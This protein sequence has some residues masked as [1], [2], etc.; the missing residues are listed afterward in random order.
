MPAGM[1]TAVNLSHFEKDYFSQ[2]LE[3]AQVQT[4]QIFDIFF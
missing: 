2:N 1:I 4:G 3:F